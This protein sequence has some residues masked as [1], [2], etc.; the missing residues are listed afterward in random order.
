MSSAGTFS[1][2]VR[3]SFA[4]RFRRVSVAVGV[5]GV[6][7]VT[8]SMPPERD[9]DCAK[10]RVE[11]VSGV[12]GH[13]TRGSDGG[14]ATALRRRTSGVGRGAC[15]PLERDFSRTCRVKDFGA[16]RLA[17]DSTEVTESRLVRGRKS[18]EAEEDASEDE[19]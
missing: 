14:K 1:P 16:G 7:G 10:V 11:E 9:S 4:S 6:V 8:G 5:T 3:F 15:L 12:M 19:S 13:C 17:E 2:S 18:E